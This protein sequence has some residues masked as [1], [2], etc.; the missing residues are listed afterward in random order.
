VLSYVSLDYQE[1]IREEMAERRVMN[2]ACPRN[3]KG[4]IL[5]VLGYPALVFYKSPNKSSV[6]EATF[7]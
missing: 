4:W 2:Y 5:P 7:I 6:I 3:Q 1:A